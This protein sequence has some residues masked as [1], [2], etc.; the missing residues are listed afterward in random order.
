MPAKNTVKIFYEDAFY[1]VYN[2]GVEKR[3]IFLDRQDYI[4]FL[5][6]LKKYL[7][8]KPKAPASVEVDPSKRFRIIPYESLSDEISLLAYC[9]M[10][11]HFH[12][13]LQQKKIDSMTK[14]L[15]CTCTSYSMYFNKKYERVGPLFQGIY[16]AANIENENYLLHLSRY[17]H[18]NPRELFTEV[19]PLT[20]D[21]PLQ[22][23][24][25]WSSYPEYVGKRKT[26]WVKTDLILSYFS[27]AKS[28][29]LSLKDLNTYQSFVEDQSSEDQGTALTPELTFD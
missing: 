21:Q 27:S 9:L 2:R 8:P 23:D 19:Q 24:Y 3:P 11:N 4:V 7:T 22:R 6:F 1:H 18:L 15:R 12:L 5:H 17:I 28:S 10:P 14:F 25:E 26:E 29:D 13:L 16:K 20:R